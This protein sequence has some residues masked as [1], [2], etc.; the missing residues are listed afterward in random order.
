MKLMKVLSVLLIVIA[1]GVFYVVSNINTVVKDAIVQVG[2]DT[3]KTTVTLDSVDI[4][5]LSSRARLSGLVIANPAG[6]S[7]PS[8]FEMD[9]IVVDLD[10]MSLLDRVIDI[11]EISIDGARVTAEQKGATTNVQA[12]LKSLESGASPSTPVPEQPAEE[13]SAPVDVL[14]KVGQ[15]D[16]VN[17][18]TELVTEKW[19]AK[20]VSI[21]AIKLSNIGGES[22]VP[23]EG[24]ANAIIKPLLKQLNKAL[25]DRLQE[26]LEDEAK[27]KA[28]EKLEEKEDELKA[29]I[30][31][32]LEEKIGDKDTVDAL[33]SLFS[34]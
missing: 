2:S 6:F 15:F 3:L 26:L 14:I 12:L 16:F 1:V 32:K 8:L 33:K 31:K 19:G 30:D 22:G 18:A 10:V 21:P 13:P 9:N 28:K 27:A 23:P 17:S 11:Q 4:L 29:K 25:K 20:D 24:L 5:L 7:A 34:K